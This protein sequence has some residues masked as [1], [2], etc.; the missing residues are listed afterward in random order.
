MT[1][2]IEELIDIH[3]TVWPDKALLVQPGDLRLFAPPGKLATG[4][5][6]RAAETAHETRMN[7]L[8]DP[9][10]A[11][12]MATPAGGTIYFPGDAALDDL[13]RLLRLLQIDAA[14]TDYAAFVDR[15]A[16]PLGQRY[17]TQLRIVRAPALVDIYGALSLEEMRRFPAQRLPI[18]EAL[19][20]FIIAEQQSRNSRTNSDVLEG[21]VR[22]RIAER[23]GFGFTVENAHYGIYRIWSRSWL[24]P[25]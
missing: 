24:D 16:D 20:A 1:S 3:P 19:R 8:A 5:A 11:A 10:R 14:A 12:P 21:A 2:R 6:P 17:V 13:V 9:F 7:R 25:Q 18:G 15:A 4:L 22:G 23:L